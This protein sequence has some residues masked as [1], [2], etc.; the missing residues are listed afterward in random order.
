M[1][2]NE[3]GEYY[4]QEMEESD[5]YK[6]DYMG[7]KTLNEAGKIQKISIAGDHLQFSDEDIDNTFVPFLMQ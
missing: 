1:A 3:S 5:L 4:L 6:E 7:L 2:V